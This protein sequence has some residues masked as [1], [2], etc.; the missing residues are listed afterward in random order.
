[1]QDGLGQQA[2]FEGILHSFR[3]RTF[4]SISA[5]VVILNCRHIYILMGSSLLE[6]EIPLVVIPA[7]VIA[8]CPVMRKHLTLAL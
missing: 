4:T 3:F 8:D 6:G 5:F 7:V 1:M 2:V